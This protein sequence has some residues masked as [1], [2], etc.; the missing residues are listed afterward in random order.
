MTTKYIRDEVYYDQAEFMKT[1]QAQESWSFNESINNNSVRIILF[2]SD[3]LYES[4]N[5]TPTDSF[6]PIF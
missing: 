1:L 4:Y 2:I 5:M 3:K 6:I